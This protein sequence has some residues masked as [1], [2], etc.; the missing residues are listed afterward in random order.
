M[1]YKNLLYSQEQGLAMIT[2]NRPKAYNALCAEL[3]AELEQLLARLETDKEVKAL[4]VTGGKKVFAAGADIM[5]MAEADSLA[6]YQVSTIGHRNHDRLEDLPFPTI[7]AINGP[8]LGGGFELALSCDFRI[9]GEKS[10]LGL[11]EITLG[12]FPGAGGTQR[13]LNLVGPSRA[14]ELIFQGNP[15]SAVK[16]LEIGIVNRVVPDDEVLAEAQKLASELMKRP[17]RAISL[18]KAA[19]NTGIN[20]PLSVGKQLE[21]TYFAMTFASPDQ[22]E[23]MK[24]FIEKR[25]PKF[26]DQ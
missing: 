5:E 14:K 7:A 18:A 12:I 3:N 4:I 8:A 6:A 11:P 23:G 15:V 24:A 16:A 13:L 19:I 2:L 25:P 1:E 17:R 10:I 21:K 26:T 9:A 20:Y 22:K